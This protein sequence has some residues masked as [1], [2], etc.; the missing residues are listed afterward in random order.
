MQ[1]VFPHLAGD[2]MALTLNSRYDK[3]RQAD[4]RALATTADLITS[5]AEASIDEV[6]K[7]LHAAT[8]N[9]KLPTLP[10]LNAE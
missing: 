10:G 2:R 5:D 1:F 9:I 8:N 4:F 6:L 3:L 7:R